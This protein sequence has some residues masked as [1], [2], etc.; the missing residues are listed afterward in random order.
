[1]SSDV[2]V[3]TRGLGKR[4][5]LHDSAWGRLADGMFG[6]G[7]GR[8][9]WALRDID[10][11]LKRGECIGIVGRNGAGK[12]TLLET[13]CGILQPSEGSVE[14]SGRI[15]ALLQLGAGFNPEFTGRENA[16]LGAALYGLGSREIESRMPA[17][18]AFADIGDFIDRPVRDYS[19]GMYARLA[20]SVCAHVDAEI[21][22][23]DEILGVGDARFQQ[24]SMRFMRAFRKRG[25]VLFVSHNEH[26]VAALCSRVI[27]ID[28]GSVAASGRT[29]DVL[30]LY[31]REMSRLMGPEQRFEVSGGPA[32][33]AMGAEPPPAPIAVESDNAGFDPDNPPATTGGGT[34]GA[35]RLAFEDGAPAVSASGGED[36]VLTVTC[37]VADPSARPHLLFALRNPMGQIVFAGDS[38]DSGDAFPPPAMGEDM[39]WEFGF[40]LPFLPTGSYPFDLF[41]LEDRD[42]TTLCLDVR[43]NAAVVQVLSRHVSSGM[44]NIA[45]D[46][47]LLLVGAE[48]G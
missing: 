46:R 5:K 35:V 45:M 15:A 31:R 17:I 38:R 1:M 13:I 44:A 47:A 27:W 16:F 23:V 43:E 7:N 30:Y 37:R 25:I 21:L 11:D 22:V 41:L 18:E 33:P 2:F 10:L 3:R 42:G 12:S 14:T 29:A 36:V 8:E 24:K 34:I 28:R 39:A 32:E 48:A 19:S 6:S 26:A 4:F 20:F 9:H 40:S